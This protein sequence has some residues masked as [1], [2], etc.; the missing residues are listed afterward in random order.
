MPFFVAGG[1]INP[2]TLKQSLIYFP[3]VPLGVWAGV[4]LNR[5]L[6]GELFSRLIYIFTLLSG[7]QLIFNFDLRRLW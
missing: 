5:R 4:W 6:P 1:L 2:A 3:I 7:L